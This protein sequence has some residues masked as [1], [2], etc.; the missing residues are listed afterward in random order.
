MLKRIFRWLRRQSSI[1]PDRN[2]LSAIGLINRQIRMQ[3]YMM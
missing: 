3:K 2:D 1:K